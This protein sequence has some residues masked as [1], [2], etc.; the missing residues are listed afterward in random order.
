MSALVKQPHPAHDTAVL[1]DTIETRTLAETHTHIHT[2][3]NHLTRNTKRAAPP[4]A[5]LQQPDALDTDSQEAHSHSP[6]R[7]CSILYCPA[8][9]FD[10]V[11]FAVAAAVAAPAN[12]SAPVLA[13][14][15]AAAAVEVL[16]LM[17]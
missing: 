11:V 17:G 15:A 12:A 9:V 13:S 10:A 1:T 8:P 7:L 5:H 16:L 14:V 6:Y 2:H 3:T 4:P